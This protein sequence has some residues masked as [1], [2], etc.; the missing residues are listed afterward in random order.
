MAFKRIVADF[1]T[2][3]PVDI[4]S[5]GAYKYAQHPD[6]D[7]TMLAVLDIDNP[8]DV[9]MWIGPN[10]R[11]LYETE[12][13][14]VELDELV[15]NSNE[16]VAHNVPFERA[17]WHYVMVRKYGFTPLD[18]RKTTDTA[19]L[20]SMVGLPRT[21]EKASE[22]LNP[23]G[24]EKDKEGAKVM[25]RFIAPKLPVTAKRKKLC[26]ENPDSIK[27][28]Y[29]RA[30][31]V[32]SIGGIPDF[33]Y[34]HFLDWHD[35]KDDFARM[36]EYCRR[37]VLAEYHLYK[38]LP[39][40]HP[41]EK[42]IWVL[43]QEINDRGICIDIESARGITKTLNQYSEDLMKEVFELTDGAVTSM[44]AP[45]QI[46]KWL[47]S[48]GIEV[49]SVDKSSVDYLLT[50]NLKPKVRRFLEIRKTLGK[51]S[52][53]KYDAMFECASIEDNRVRGIHAFA[54]AQTGRWCLAEGTPILVFT[55]EGDTMFKPIE[56]VLL[57]DKVFDGDEWVNHEGVVCNGEK[58]VV[59]YRGLTATPDHKV[60][61]NNEEKVEFGELI[62]K[63]GK[64]WKGI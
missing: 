37:D 8:S 43:D 51:S 31:E 3:S 29:T 35:D 40:L 20:C 62:E 16:F 64:I 6:T 36:V 19:V 50:L 42:D 28:G 13:S 49:D 53:A 1:E 30:M 60:F 15:F 7:V 9:R 26:P 58:D 63:G 22:F 38:T 46:K 33:E 61:I 21:L 57:T 11:H 24:T 34:H 59:T 14:D 2:R 45:A 48:E 52:V 10:F 41:S 25:K 32:L 23:A 17:I 55:V 27:E 44:K 5:C 12:I 39:P 54:G 56:C 4:K 47:L 18:V